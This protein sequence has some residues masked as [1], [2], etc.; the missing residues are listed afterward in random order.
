LNY[1][2]T[3]G[4]GFIGTILIQKLLSDGHR[5]TALVRSQS[6][7]KITQ[8]QQ[9]LEWVEGDILDPHSL[10]PALQNIDRVFH[11]A[12]RA[13][14]WA[15]NKQDFFDINVQ[16][17]LNLLEAAEKAGA[18]RFVF[19]STA[20]TL[21]P[22]DP[23][24]PADEHSYKTDLLTPYEDSKYQAEES[25]KSF[26]RNHHLQAVIVNP[27]RVFGPGP[28]S[29]SNA[30]TRLIK[31]Y[32]EGKWHFL[33]GDGSAIGNYCYVRDLVEGHL[34]AMENGTAGEQYILG[35]HNLSFRSFFDLIGEVSSKK[36]FLLPLP[37]PL[38]QGFSRFEKD[39]ATYLGG[40]PV[41]TPGWM[42]KYLQNWAV[43]STKAR[44]ELG[45]TITPIREAL[46]QTIHW[47]QRQ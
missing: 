26:T 15:P 47:L 24:T 30:V 45:Y 46:R 22:A 29:E 16:G 44:N 20:A 2:V 28:L 25:V 4:T 34:L 18:E 1:F 39:R 12:G 17:T 32:T 6:T 27:T 36:R 23:D 9:N 42:N 19:T 33:P 10:E 35:G 13:S 14:V 40:A 41:I 3:G 8:N 43:T 38:L 11:M 31:F 37:A 5:V 21:P 7:H